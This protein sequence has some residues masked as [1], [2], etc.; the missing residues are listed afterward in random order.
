VRDLAATRP[1]RPVA[2]GTSATRPERPVAAGCAG[3]DGAPIR[4]RFLCCCLDVMS[5]NCYA[6]EFVLLLGGH[7]HQ[8][9][10]LCLRI[11]SILDPASGLFF[12]N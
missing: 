10:L 5:T 9:L 11:S 12:F 2:C 7:V 4:R 1:E 3:A 6:Y 8:L